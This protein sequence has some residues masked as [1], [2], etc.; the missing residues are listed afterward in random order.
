MA[1]TLTNVNRITVFDQCLSALKVA[2]SPV[3]VF[4]TSYD[5]TPGTIGATVYVPVISSQ[6]A[7]TATTDYESGDGSAVSVAV[8]LSQNYSRSNH[9]T[10]IEASKTS[11]DAFA[12]FMVE[13][14]YSVGYQIQLDTFSLITTAF[15][16]ATSATAAAD[17]DSDKL[18]DVKAACVNLGYRN[19]NCVLDT[20]Y[21]TNLLK[22]PAV[23]DKSASGLDAGV[24]GEL[25]RFAGMNIYSNPIV[26]S[27]TGV[28]ALEGFICEPS[29]IGVTIRPPEIVGTSAYEVI[30]NI[31]DETGIAVQ[32]REWVASNSN[33]RW[34][35][36]ETLWGGARV[37]VARLYRIQSA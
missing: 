36:I 27:S 20:L 37:D 34:A 21:Y 31:T 35:C 2:L 26:T 16:N 8:S 14:A 15:T 1:N 11:T 29:A 19:M 17:F 7:S 28:A 33:T 6:T 25:M 30:E 10:A 24:S 9:L 13:A 4:S 22:D 5:S 18:L 23:K 32:Y 12:K 3:S